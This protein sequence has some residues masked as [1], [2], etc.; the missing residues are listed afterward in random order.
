MKNIL[1]LLCQDVV[2]D[3]ETNQWNLIRHIENLKVNIPK[4]KAENKEKIVLNGQFNL[5]TFW[6]NASKG[7][8]INMKFRLVNK[9]GEV[10]MESSE[11]KAEIKDDGPLYKYR[12]KLGKIILKRSGSYYFQL[13]RKQGGK[14]KIEED[15]EIKAE[16]N[17]QS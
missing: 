4:E 7:E 2:I 6:K 3:K 17:S 8:E 12:I 13:F 11:Y 14:Y 15:Y 16:I 10:L 9:E 1:F 5:V